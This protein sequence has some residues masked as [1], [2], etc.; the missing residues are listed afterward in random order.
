M[1][2]ALRAMD[3]RGSS[4]RASQ[5]F[6]Q[7]QQASGAP[8][9]ALMQPAMSGEIDAARV[10]ELRAS[11]PPQTRQPDFPST[12]RLAT[13]AKF[14]ASGASTAQPSHPVAPFPQSFTQVKPQPVGATAPPASVFTAAHN[15]NT[16]DAPAATEAAHPMGAAPPPRP[17]PPAVPFPVRFEG[18]AVDGC[19]PGAPSFPGPAAPS[20][21]HPINP[22]SPASQANYRAHRSRS[23]HKGAA[24]NGAGKP[25]FAAA[26]T[27][28]GPAAT[29]P[30]PAE[31][32][33]SFATFSGSSTGAGVPLQPTSPPILAFTAK[34]QA[35]GQPGGM[36]DPGTHLPGYCLL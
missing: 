24:G 8:Q 26:A 27:S 10:S 18:T 3:D 33:S 5:T 22:F 2:A 36:H 32:D 28:D 17:P 19:G 12:G 21:R 23:P 6:T 4:V 9:D 31:P 11:M 25:L 14:F 16:Q 35:A 20:A 29:P 7:Q 15:S 34:R 1:K 30:A 13:G